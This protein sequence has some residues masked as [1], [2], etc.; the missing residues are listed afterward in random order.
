MPHSK[1]RDEDQAGNGHGAD[2]QRAGSGPL[3]HGARVLQAEQIRSARLQRLA[4]LGQR[5]ADGVV[6]QHFGDGLDRPCP[7]PACVSRSSTL[8]VGFSRGRSQANSRSAT[9][10]RSGVLA[11]AVADRR[12][13]ADQHVAD[14][15]DLLRRRDGPP[16]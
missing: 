10:D 6:D 5:L 13:V 15:D 16:G 4:R 8:N 2:Q 3:V 14:A 12:A 7:S 11:E 9:A 1:K